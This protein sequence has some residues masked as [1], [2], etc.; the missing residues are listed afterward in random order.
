MVFFGGRLRVPTRR[1]DLVVPADWGWGRSNEYL[2]LTTLCV[3]RSVTLFVS[4]TPL[5]P[6]THHTQCREVSHTL[7]VHHTF[8]PNRTPYTIVVI[9]SPLHPLPSLVRQ[10][11]AMEAAVTI[12][13]LRRASARE[14]KAHSH[15]NETDAKRVAEKIKEREC[16]ARS[17][18]N[19]T[20][21][22]RAAEK[23]RERLFVGANSS[24]CDVCN[25]KKR[26]QMEGSFC[27]GI[28]NHS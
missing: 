22:K 13:N 21:A 24:F 7:C 16:K 3:G 28:H 14:R 15:A 5:A 19:Q 20:D 6:T 10:Q 4:V 8:A 23:I 26:C 1:C 11:P 2:V 12:I 17:H 9:P 25:A 27:K 18:A